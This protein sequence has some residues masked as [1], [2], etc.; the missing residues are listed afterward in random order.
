MDLRLERI[1]AVYGLD[2]RLS[3]SDVILDFPV[4]GVN[5]LSLTRTTGSV[6]LARVP[7]S[8]SLGKLSQERVCRQRARTLQSPTSLNKCG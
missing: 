4:S 1:A 6:S 3:W 8:R 2:A 7:R 5:S